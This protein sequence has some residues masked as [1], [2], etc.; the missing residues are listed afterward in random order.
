MAKTSWFS[1]VLWTVPI[2]AG[3]LL[4][5]SH[6]LGWMVERFDAADSFYSHGW[7]IP[8]PVGWLLWQNRKAFSRK[9]AQPS[10]EGLAFLAAML[11]LHLIGSWLRIGFVSGFAMIGAIW[12]LVWT[13]WGW[14][15]LRRVRFPM[16]F[17][18]FMV[19]LPSIL[20]I[21]TSFKMK[22]MAAGLATQL[23][24]GM[25]LEAI[26][27]GSTI[28]LNGINLVV[29]DTCSGLRSLISLFAL[30]VLWTSLLPE[31]AKRWHKIVLVAAAAPI[32]LA[33]N[34]IRIMV[35][36]LLAVFYGAETAEGFI[37]F[38]SGM[39]VFGLAVILFWQL[40]RLMVR[41]PSTDGAGS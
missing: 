40:S 12:G 13:F 17:L 4:V 35:L 1:R 6:T 24:S 20:L 7:L 28:H 31:T 32:A 34:M 41:E 38:G 26:Q 16:L 27:A 21:A 37:H 15:T 19:P 39:V 14:D 22:L 36:S 3:M 9:L 25:G 10:A 18:L 30:A 29:D 8:L 33:T 5:F 11:T 2:L 23:L